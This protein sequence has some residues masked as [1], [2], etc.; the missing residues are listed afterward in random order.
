MGPPISGRRNDSFKG[1]LVFSASLRFGQTQ[2]RQGFGKSV[3]QKGA[4]GTQKSG[5]HR[6]LQAVRGVGML[7]RGPCGSM[8]FV[9]TV[10]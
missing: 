1:L 2:P 6:L 5:Q 4:L 8:S 3:A 7:Q 9:V 10:F